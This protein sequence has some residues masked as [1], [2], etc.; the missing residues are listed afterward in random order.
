MEEWAQ[1]EHL[2]GFQLSELLSSPEKGQ[3]WA[4]VLASP[5]TIAVIITDAGTKTTQRIAGSRYSRLLFP[6]WKPQQQA[7]PN[8]KRTSPRAFRDH[9]PIFAPHRHAKQAEF[10]SESL[11]TAGRCRTLGLYRAAA[12]TYDGNSEGGLQ[13]DD[14]SPRTKC[15]LGKRSHL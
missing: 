12:Q 4:M 10:H 7:L 6:A 15:D 13:L 11:C 3:G 8:S 5:I 1:T 9:S 14:Y 2:F